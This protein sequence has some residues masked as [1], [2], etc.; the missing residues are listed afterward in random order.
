MSENGKIH[1]AGKDFTLPLAVTGETNL[2]S[3]WGVVV[4]VGGYYNITVLKGKLNVK[5]PFLL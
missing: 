4:V 2:T 5:I 1:I 3:G